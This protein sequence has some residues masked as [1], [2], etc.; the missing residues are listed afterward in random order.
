M[1]AQP[2]TDNPGQAGNPTGSHCVLLVADEIFSGSDVARELENHLERPADEVEIKVISAAISHNRLDQELGNIDEALPQAEDR[3]A[4]IVKQLGDAGF[5]TEGVTGDS[6]LLVAIGDGLAQYR[7]DEIVAVVHVEDESEPVERGIWDRLS[8][9]F[10]EPVTL[11]RVHHPH[12]QELP[13]VE[14]VEH[15]AAHEKTHEEV[16]R[17]TRNFP[18]LK[19]RDVAG[20]IFGVLGT[21]GLG[22]IA[23]L[24]GTQEQGSE[25]SD[26]ALSGDAAIILLIAMGAFLINV[27]HVVGLVFFQS[28]RYTGIW[29]KFMA[30]TSIV[31]TSVG[32][33]VSLIL[34]LA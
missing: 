13:E 16:I 27:A 19:T 25:G 29:E 23:L 33:V 2:I 10:R 32:L 4:T 28:V 20:I 7:P 5:C 9:D 22:I 6:D 8:T 18:P 1:E 31:V 11:L 15:A 24:A 14:S 21:I 26:R 30:R 17:E 12:G 3:L 34:H